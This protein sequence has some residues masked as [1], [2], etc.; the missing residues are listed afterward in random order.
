MR[1][2]A[3]SW[4]SFSA[5]GGKAESVLWPG[6]R[7]S[8]LR[9]IDST[10]PGIKRRLVLLLSILLGGR[11]TGWPQLLAQPVVRAAGWEVVEL[12]DDAIPEFLVEAP[13]LEAERCEVGMVASAPACLLF[14]G[15]EE[16]PSI[17]LVTQAL[18]NPEIIDVQPA[19]E[20]RSGETTY[21]RALLV[22]NEDVQRCR[23]MRP[24]MPVVR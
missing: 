13:G 1:C 17:S 12:S 15:E 20:R 18:V 6:F 4:I 5:H 7:S 16:L 9:T 8:V 10:V 11:F 21:D 19:P 3:E 2:A 23:R 14:G 24:N 22:S